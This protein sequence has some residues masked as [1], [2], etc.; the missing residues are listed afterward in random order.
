[1]TNIFA[2]HKLQLEGH[3]NVYFIQLTRKWG[4]LTNEEVQGDRNS[5]QLKKYT[6]IFAFLQKNDLTIKI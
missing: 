2:L 4:E 3:Y 6:E 5:L 1:M